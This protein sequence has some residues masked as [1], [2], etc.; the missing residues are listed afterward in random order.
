MSIRKVVVRYRVQPVLADENARLIEAVFAE[1]ARTAPAGVAYTAL[2]LADGV[3]FM[4]VATVTD[5]RLNAL[6]AFQAFTRDIA[7]RC[8]EPPVT[9]EMTVVGAYGAFAP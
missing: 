3:S 9:T 4:H 5:G 2:R 8:V 6:P 7:A 1:L